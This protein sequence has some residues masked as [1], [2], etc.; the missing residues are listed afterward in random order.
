MTTTAMTAGTSH[1]GRPM[2]LRSAGRRATVEGLGAGARGVGGT[3]AGRA[4]AGGEGAVV[5]DENDGLSSVPPPLQTGAATGDQVWSGAFVSATW[6]SGALVSLAGGA[7][8]A[9]AGAQ[10]AAGGGAG[11]GSLKVGVAGVA[12]AGGFVALAPPAGMLSNGDAGPEA[13]AA[14]SQRAAGGG[15]Y[16]AGVGGAGSGAAAG[17]GAAGAVGGLVSIGD[18]GAE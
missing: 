9:A 14:G 1:A 11:V 18:W 6:L 17:G 10:V 5:E 15:S 3:V 2:G 4:P 13:G 16:G 8:D 12:G 7:V